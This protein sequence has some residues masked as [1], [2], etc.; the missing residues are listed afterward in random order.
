[1]NITCLKENLKRILNIISGIVGKNLTLPILN[2]I[3]IEAQEEG[4]KISA[5]NLEIGL[6]AFVSG[7]IEKKGVLTVP[8]KTLTSFISNLPNKKIQLEAKKNILKISSDNY[9][10]EINGLPAEEF[11]I[12]P[13]FSQKFSYKIPSETL[14]EAL[15]SVVSVAA[16]SDSRPEITG[17]FLMFENSK[18]LVAATDSFRLAEKTILLENKKES[19]KQEIKTILPQK[20][21]QELTKILSENTGKEVS[22]GFE[23]NQI[24]LKIGDFQIVSR[25]IDGVY[26]DY[27]QIIPR[28]S[29]FSLALDKEELISSIRLASVF[30]SKINETK[31]K[32]DLK[33]KKLTVSSADPEV[34]TN[35]SEIAL[36]VEKPETPSDKILEISFNHRFLLDGLNNLKGKKAIFS[37][38][39]ETTPGVL[40]SA[41]DSSYLYLLMPINAN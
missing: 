39:S 38:N 33:R 28:E 6:S 31:F 24:F 23:N 40:R 4:I 20:T 18:V 29:A 26:P 7:K 19:T 37:L 11:P 2:N 32:F 17:V 8:A 27:Q 5:T 35:E 15:S 14:K 16:I 13:K 3:L 36:E 12:I 21:A 1:M 41:S 30:S 10:A 34:G 22:I 25:L 9:K